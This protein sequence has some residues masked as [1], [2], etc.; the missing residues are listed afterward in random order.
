MLVS[1][2]RNGSYEGDSATSAG[3]P[4]IGKDRRVEEKKSKQE[5]EDR[6]FM[7]VMASVLCSCLRRYVLSLQTN[8]FLRLC[9]D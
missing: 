9:L 6:L 8:P 1:G 7:D 4:L 5:N 3:A 2:H